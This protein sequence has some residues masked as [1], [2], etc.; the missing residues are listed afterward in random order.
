MRLK[1]LQ[2]GHRSAQSLP[3]VTIVIWELDGLLSCVCL[4]LDLG[5]TAIPT[6]YVGREGKCRNQKGEHLKNHC[7]HARL[8]STSMPNQSKT[9]PVNRTIRN[10]VHWGL[11]GSNN[12]Y[13]GPKTIT[14]V[15]ASRRASPPISAVFRFSDKVTSVSGGS[16]V[17]SQFCRSI[18]GQTGAVT[19]WRNGSRYSFS[20]RS[21]S[22]EYS[23]NRS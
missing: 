6:E 19:M 1:P 17:V 20:S 7:C 16:N 12:S 18:E 2:V 23:P 10:T 22:D 15:P 8:L 14:S 21:Y 5:F 13:S 9:K 4:I 11:A 3:S